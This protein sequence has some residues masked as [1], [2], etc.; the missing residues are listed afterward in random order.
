ML[1]EF[2]LTLRLE[3]RSWETQ[4]SLISALLPV[5]KVWLFWPPAARLDWFSVVLKKKKKSF[6]KA[7]GLLLCGFNL[8]RHLSKW[9]SAS[10][11]VCCGE[12]PAE[13]NRGCPL[14]S[15]WEGVYWTWAPRTSSHSIWRKKKHTHTTENE[16]YYQK[17]RSE[18]A[19]PVVL[20]WAAD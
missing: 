15:R 2:E 9:P 8:R 19:G 5:A 13:V 17:V 3:L 12:L 10:S 1:N 7:Q 11:K 6:L 4:T 16:L 18:T 14:P 20:R